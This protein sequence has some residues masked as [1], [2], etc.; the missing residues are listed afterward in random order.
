MGGGIRF[1]PTSTKSLC[2]PSLS[3]S[4]PGSRG[5]LLR[6]SPDAPALLALYFLLGGAGALRRRTVPSEASDACPA[7]VADDADRGRVG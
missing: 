2:D 1:P 6:S 7:E 4:V 5:V 3:S